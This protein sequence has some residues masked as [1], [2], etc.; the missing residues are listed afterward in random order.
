MSVKRALTVFFFLKTHQGANKITFT[1]CHSG[2]LKL[3]FTSP[4]IISTS[5]KSVWWAELISQFFC[6]SNS[7]K[8]IT[9]PSGKLKTEFNSPIEKFTSPGL[10]DISF[11][12]RCSLKCI[13]KR[14]RVCFD[15]IQHRFTV[16]RDKHKLSS[17][18][19]WENRSCLLVFHVSTSKHFLLNQ[20]HNFASLLGLNYNVSY[21][22]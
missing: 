6:Y 2:K 1:A 17:V 4:D 7:S 19:I 9:C 16:L 12:A 5:H 14:N 8:N 13:L 20:Y 3:A 18:F 22:N 21:K 15:S 11:F 10:S